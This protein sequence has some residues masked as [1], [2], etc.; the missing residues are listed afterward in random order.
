M[1]LVTYVQ[2]VLPEFSYN[3]YF[4]MH[5]CVSIHGSQERLPNSCHCSLETSVLTVRSWQLWPLDPDTDNNDLKLKL[6]VLSFRAV[7][8]TGEEGGKATGIK[9]KINEEQ[10]DGYH[11]NSD[12][13][14]V[15][16]LYGNG[17]WQ[18]LIIHS[19]PLYLYSTFVFVL[20][21]D[22]VLV[23]EWKLYLFGVA[24][25]LICISSP[26]SVGSDWK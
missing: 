12:D 18:L 3:F 19:R 22:I 20:R 25:G 24:E 23:S 5:I 8:W 21:A 7:E 11:G 2:C 17:Y 6:K 16:T 15:Y 4:N 1:L 14:W 13:G 26:R 10:Y 9:T